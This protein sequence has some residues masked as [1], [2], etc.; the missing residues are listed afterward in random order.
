MPDFIL[1][2]DD[3]VEFIAVPD[4][5]VLITADNN[6]EF[7]VAAAVQGPEGIQGPPGFGSWVDSLINTAGTHTLPD[8]TNNWIDVDS[9]ASDVTIELPHQS[10]WVKKSLR[11]H[12]VVDA[13]KVIVTIQAGDTFA[14]PL[15]NNTWVLYSK[16]ELLE[17]TATSTEW[18]IS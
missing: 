7:I 1:V 17:T 16:D 11:I 12:K 8:D 2:D 13:H 15:N 14:T 3:I 4:N 5:T 9:T 18:N 10:A 6:V